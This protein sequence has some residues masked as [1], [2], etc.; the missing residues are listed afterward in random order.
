MFIS[1]QNTYVDILSWMC[2]YPDVALMTRGHQRR[3][4][5]NEISTAIEEN[6]GSLVCLFLRV[7]AEPEGAIS[8]GE[9]ALTKGQVFW[10]L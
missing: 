2:C 8:E 7:R 1:L 4:L 9:W 5:V 6:T 10:A 3:A